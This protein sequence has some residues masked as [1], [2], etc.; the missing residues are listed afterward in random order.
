MSISEYFAKFFKPFTVDVNTAE[1]IRIIP[2]PKENKNNIKIA[3]KILSEIDA[4]AIIPANIGVEHGVPASAKTIPKS[5]GYIIK[6]L[7]F[8]VGICLINTGK[9]KSKTPIT[10][11]HI[12]I[13]KEAIIN[14]KYVGATDTNARPVKAHIIPIT[15][16]TIDVPKTKNNICISVFVGLS[17]EY[18]P[19][20]PMII[21][22]ID[23]EHGDIDAITPPANDNNNAKKLKLLPDVCNISKKLFIT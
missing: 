6:P 16:N 8:D 18:P 13:N 12:M 1:I 3:Y 9:L 19:T 20:Y 14:K 21:G 17:F 7:S 10:F 4:K 5:I 23:R 11:N 22:S 2:C 15:E